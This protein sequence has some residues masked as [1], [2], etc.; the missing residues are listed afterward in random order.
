[1]ASVMATSS[2]STGISRMNE[3]S[4]LILSIGYFFKYDNDEY[5]VPKSSTA[6]EMPKSF[7][8][9]SVLLMAVTSSMKRLSVNSS[10]SISPG[11]PCSF[12]RAAISSTRSFCLN[13]TADKLTAIGM[14]M[15]MS[16]HSRAWRIASLMTQRPIGMMRPRCSATEMN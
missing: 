8:R 9:C 14:R 15:P 12:K 1:M 3:R 10:S 5:P 4:I 7:S 11:T 16:A 2:G 13:C 6:S